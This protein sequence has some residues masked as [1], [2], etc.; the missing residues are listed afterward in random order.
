M[1]TFSTFILLMLDNKNTIII[2]VAQ[3]DGF[4]I[5]LVEMLF[6]SLTGFYMLSMIYSYLL[7]WKHDIKE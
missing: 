5:I 2:H 6:I 3:N 1:N 4:L 7:G